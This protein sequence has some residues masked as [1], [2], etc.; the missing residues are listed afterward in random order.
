M[1]TCKDCIHYD[2]CQYHIDEETTMTINECTHEFAH[3]E[4]Y[5]KLPVF[6]GQTVWR[7]YQ[8]Y[9][10]RVD[11]TN[12][13]VSMLQQ[14][15]DKSWKFRFSESGTGSVGDYVLDD[16]NTRIF[17]TKEAAEEKAERL[18]RSFVE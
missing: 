4:Q 5:I 16:L 6:V 10:G 15:A 17:L 12:G 7:V 1:Y 13:K 18:R 8:A 11:V 3:K 9:S 2:I 14:K